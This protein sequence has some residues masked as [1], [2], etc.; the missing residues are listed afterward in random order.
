MTTSTRPFVSRKRLSSQIA[1]ETAA[2]ANAPTERGAPG[3]SSSGTPCTWTA[4]L[5][6]H[7]STRAPCMSQPLMRK[8]A[9]SRNCFFAPDAP[10]DR[11]VE[12]LRSGE[13]DGLAALSPEA[14]RGMALFLREGELRPSLQRSEL[15]GREFHNNAL[16]T[17]HGGEPLDAGRYDGAG[18]VKAS[19]FNAAGRHSD[20]PDGEAASAI[21]GLRRSSESWGEFRTPLLRNLSGRAPFMHQGQLPDLAAA[22]LEF[23]SEMAGTSVRGHH[24]E[25]FLQPLRLQGWREGCPDG[26]PRRPG[27]PTCRPGAPRAARL[28]TV[29]PFP[30]ASQIAL[31]RF[32]DRVPLGDPSSRPG[33]AR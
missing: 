26:V 27:R 7:T 12:G 17:L 13:E 3:E 22:V 14:Q 16:P 30:R 32:P 19:L 1:P 8:P 5:A 29:R 23:Y 31:N 4:A 33:P 15:L 9:G 6:D 21:R 18:V 20:A 24:Q 28:A 2:L 10:F 11:F 25:Q